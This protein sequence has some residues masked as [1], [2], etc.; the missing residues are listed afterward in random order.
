MGGWLGD[1]KRGWEVGLGSHS[2]LR[3]RHKSIKKNREY[4]GNYNGSVWRV[5]GTHGEEAGDAM[6]VGVCAPLCLTLCDPRDWSPLGSSTHGILQARILERVAIPFSRGSSRPRD[7]T[8]VS[9]AAGSFLHCRLTLY[10]LSQHSTRLKTRC[11][12]KWTRTLRPERRLCSVAGLTHG[13]KTHEDTSWGQKPGSG[14]VGTPRVYLLPNH[15]GKEP[16][17]LSPGARGVL[18]A[19]C[20]ETSDWRT[21]EPPLCWLQG[22]SGAYAPLLPGSP[23]SKWETC[24]QVITQ[25]GHPGRSG[26]AWEIREG[27]EKEGLCRT[28]SREEG[29]RSRS[30]LSTAKSPRGSLWCQRKRG[31]GGWLS[32]CRQ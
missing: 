17:V 15:K 14:G 13:S 9:C 10:Q 32:V 31:R 30:G 20:S 27:Y 18:W 3:Q 29:E 6:P 2:R 21:V 22:H 4:S 1:K 5:Q 8:Q 11:V 7:R 16:T 24:N 23:P 28:R 12:I 25:T 19:S 26:L